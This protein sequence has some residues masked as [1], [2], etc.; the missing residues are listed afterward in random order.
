MAKTKGS[1]PPLTELVYQ[2]ASGVLHYVGEFIRG[3]F[4]EGY[5]S[6]GDPETDISGQSTRGNR[7]TQRGDGSPDQSQIREIFRDCSALWN[8]L[9]EA[10]PDPVPDPPPTSKESVWAVKLEEGVV[11]SYYD[12]FMRCCISWGLAHGGMMPDGDCFPCEPT[13]NCDDILIGFTTSSMLVNEEQTLSVLGIIDGC[14]YQ[15]ELVSGGGSLSSGSG[16]STVYTAP[17][18]NPSCLENATITLSVGSDVCDTLNIAT[19]ARTGDRKAY[20]ISTCVHEFKCTI[21][22]NR[23]RCETLVHAL[24]YD[25]SSRYLYYGACFSQLRVC[26]IPGTTCEDYCGH[27]DGQRSCEEGAVIS[28]GGPIGTLTDLRTLY[29]IQH[30][31]CPGALL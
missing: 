20:T 6:P 30:G 15:W 10:C 21:V 19:N 7:P 1:N 11:C 22:N 25:C 12:L 13:C 29:D 16:S 26:S 23:P 8:S 14:T 5:V 17:A 28:C 3:L 31:C 9:P 27:F 2:D 18:S 4:N 24:Y